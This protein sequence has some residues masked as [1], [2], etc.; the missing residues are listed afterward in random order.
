GLVSPILAI[1]GG[2]I[3]FIGSLL[4]N[5]FTVLIFQC[6]CLLFCLICHYIYQKNNPKTH[7]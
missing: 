3:L 4:S 1:L 2:L 7:E 5:F 6:F